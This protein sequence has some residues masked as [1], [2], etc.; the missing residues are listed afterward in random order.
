MAKFY[1]G[2]LLV[3]SLLATGCATTASKDAHANAPVKPQKSETTGAKII[4]G[5]KPEWVDGDILAYPRLQ[6]MTA[7]AEGPTEEEAALEAQ[8]KLA[9]LFVVD[10]DALNIPMQQ[11]IDATGFQQI[12]NL[13]GPESHTVAS[14]QAER[15]LNK[16]DAAEVWLDASQGVY[17]A[18]AVLPRNT[19]K[20][21]LVKEIQLLDKRTQELIDEARNGQIDPLTQAGK[22]AKAWRAQ[23]LRQVF[24]TS[25]RTKADLTGRGIEPKWDSDTLEQDASGLLTTL[26]IEATGLVDDMNAQRVAQMIR[27]GLKVAEIKPPVNEAD[28]VMR[29][30]LDA[31]VVGA[32]NNWAVGGGELKLA[33]AD[34]VTGEVRGTKTWQVKVPGLD[35]N[36]AIRRVYEKTEYMLKVNMRDILLEM[37]MQ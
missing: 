26:Q 30:T 22:M 23:Q 4:T 3:I 6:Y 1:A 9:H 24:E 25:L 29:G 19:G 35:E 17:H 16:I 36:A 7:R 28:Y 5:E 13:V 37:S 21:Y 15:V 20:G 32:E 18:L 14:D 12:T 8:A 27:D 11:A 31:Q 10:V 33:L 2:T 34:K